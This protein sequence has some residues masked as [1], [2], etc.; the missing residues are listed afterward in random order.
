MFKTLMMTAL[1]SGVSSMALA[2]GGGEGGSLLSLDMLFKLIN[3]LLLLY[4]LHRFARKPLA[5]MLSSSAENTKKSVDETKLE[6]AEAKKQLE[7]YKSKLSNLE[8][9]L[10]DRRETALSVI[11]TEKKQ[12]IEDAENQ[13]KRIEEQSYARIEQDISNAKEEIRQFL[14]EESVKLAE[15]TIAKEIGGK[16]QKALLDHYTKSLKETA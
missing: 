16:E 13:V 15:A 1:L 7:E 10:E 3:F 9:D 11:E 8:K 2:S 14:V 6:L 5:N 12:L 4:L